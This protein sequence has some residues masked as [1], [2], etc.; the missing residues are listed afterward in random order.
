MTSLSTIAILLAAFAVVFV[1]SS[2]R[3]VRV[4]LGAQVD[5]L[6]ALMTYTALS[7]SLTTVTLL[8]ICGGLWFDSFSANPLGITILPL[9]ITGVLIHYH[10]SLWLRDHALARV[11]LGL[12][13][14]ATVPVLVL[15]LLLATGRNPLIGWSSLWQWLVLAVSGALFTPLWFELFDRLNQAIRYPVQADPP[16]RADRDI[17]RGR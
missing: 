11:L 5:L 1:E 13:A 8:A 10:R 14:S 17:K 15:I 2:F 4:T 7:S 12:A 3:S 9:F 6:P 16:F